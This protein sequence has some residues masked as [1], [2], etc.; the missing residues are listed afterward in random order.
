MTLK[1]SF[2][3]AFNVN[4]AK[5]LQ[6][7]KGLTLSQTTSFGIYQT[8]SVCRQQFLYSCKYSKILQR[9]RNCSLRAISSCP[10]VMSNG[11]YWSNVKTRACSG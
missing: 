8:E 2:V 7:R 10:T 5:Y 11:F 9:G 4:K 3:N 1:L 6:S